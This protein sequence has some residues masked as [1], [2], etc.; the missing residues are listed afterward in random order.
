MEYYIRR[1]FY[2]F[3]FA[4][5]QTYF[6][7]IFTILSCRTW[8]ELMKYVIFLTTPCQLSRSQSR[9]A[10][11]WSQIT[12]YCYENIV[13]PS[14]SIHF[15]RIS[16]QFLHFTQNF[17]TKT[18]TDF[19]HIVPL[20]YCHKYILDEK[21]NKQHFTEILNFTAGLSNERSSIE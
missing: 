16:F 20:K 12:H 10:I 8:C 17:A 4:W 21:Y 13:N 7:P 18:V 14:L 1:M 19:H 2:T 9:L 3:M 5:R 6:S 15:C 11:N